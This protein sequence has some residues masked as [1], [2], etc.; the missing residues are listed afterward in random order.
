MRTKIAALGGLGI[1][2][3]IL[4]LVAVLTISALTWGWLLMVIAGAAGWHIGFGT[5]F[6]IGIGI[7]ILVGTI[8]QGS[9]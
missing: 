3:V 6:V 9:K 8:Q 7:T 2:A 5:A 1:V 4:I